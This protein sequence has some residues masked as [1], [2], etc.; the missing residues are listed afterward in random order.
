MY[1]VGLEKPINDSNFVFDSIK[2]WH[3]K[4]HCK[5]QSWQILNRFS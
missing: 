5:S 1:Q 2:G 4:C 3:C